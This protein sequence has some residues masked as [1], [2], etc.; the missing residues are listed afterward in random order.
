[1]EDFHPVGGTLTVQNVGIQKTHLQY[2]EDGFL[3]PPVTASSNCI[4]TDQLIKMVD[5]PHVIYVLL[6]DFG[7]LHHDFL[8]PASV[9]SFQSLSVN[10]FVCGYIIPSGDEGH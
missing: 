4:I 2:I 7:P 6:Y 3:C 1:M 5:A 10:V 8:I 9:S